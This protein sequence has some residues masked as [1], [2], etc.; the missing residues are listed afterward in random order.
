MLLLSLLGSDTHLQFNG[1][2]T[3]ACMQD[4]ATV[5]YVVRSTLPGLLYSLEVMELY[6]MEVVD[7]PILVGSHTRAA[8]L[9]TAPLV[10]MPL[11]L[12]LAFPAWQLALQAPEGQE[13]WHENMA[14]VP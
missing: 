11:P 7:Q 5:I 13:H 8:R 4:G 3:S 14:L 6:R 9:Q 12:V 1:L 10:V 2:H